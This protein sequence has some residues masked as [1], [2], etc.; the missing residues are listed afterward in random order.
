MRSAGRACQPLPLRTKAFATLRN[1]AGDEPRSHTL[2]C[3]EAATVNLLQSA[4]IRSGTGSGVETAS[5]P[6]KQGVA[7]SSPAPPISRKPW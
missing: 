5:M 1:P 4:L 7:G 3:G 2:P 6:Y